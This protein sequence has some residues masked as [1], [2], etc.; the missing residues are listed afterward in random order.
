MGLFNNRNQINN[1][2]MVPI[3]FMRQAGR[4]HQHYQNL[5]KSHTFMELCKNPEL[6][7]EVTLG[8]IE[9]FGFNAAILFSD[10]LFPLEYLNLGLSYD[11]GRPE[12]SKQLN[13][14]TN[15]DDLKP[16]EP[17]SSFFAF[18]K[19]ACALLREKLPQNVDLLGFVGA[20]FTLLTYACEGEHSGSLVDTK[21]FMHSKSF[22][23]FMEKLITCILEEASL[24]LDGGADTMCF[25]DTA[26]GE[27]CLSDYEEFILPYLERVTQTLKAKYHHKKIVYYSR[28]TH[29]N[30]LKKLNNC[31]IDVLGLDWRIDLKEAFAT[32]GDRY[33]LQGNMDPAWLHLPWEI[34]EKK[35][36]K[37]RSKLIGYE[38]YFDRYIFGLGHGVLVKTPEVNVFNTVNWVKANYQY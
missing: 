32:F 38:K 1:K 27:L 16:T 21:K 5:K 37:Q 3:W 4:Y 11:S 7:C 2:K 36:E 30:Y 28:N 26:V 10:L 23:P 24:Q 9:S 19:N 13:E 35:L 20:P 34:L 29:L 31:A 33:Y 22:H 8:P 12:L 15:L 18:Q 6:A 25:F 17:T 14:Q